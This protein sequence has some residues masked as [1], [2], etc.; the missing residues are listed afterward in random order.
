MIILCNAE[1]Q[2]QQDEQII[3]MIESAYEASCKALNDLDKKDPSDKDMIKLRT[4]VALS[5][6]KV[7]GNHLTEN[8]E[9]R[10]KGKT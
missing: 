10:T 8:S 1:S 7:L 6:S 5:S 2:T 4:E 3:M 9:K